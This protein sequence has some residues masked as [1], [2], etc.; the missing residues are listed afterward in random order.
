MTKYIKFQGKHLGLVGGTG[1]RFGAFIPNLGY[2]T[3]EARASYIEVGSKSKTFDEKSNFISSSVG[4]LASSVAKDN[5]Y[6]AGIK[7]FIF[8]YQG[9]LPVVVPCSQCK[10]KGKACS[11][12]PLTAALLQEKAKILEES[13]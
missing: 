6:G 1:L 8:G 3:S 5:K 10:A 13:K 7:Y 12:N 4:E 11:C 2:R 9:Y